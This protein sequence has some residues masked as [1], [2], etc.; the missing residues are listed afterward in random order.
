MGRSPGRETRVPVCFQRSLLPKA[1]HQRQHPPPRPVPLT[2]S[3]V[4][5]HLV[6]P[7]VP[8]GSGWA[9]PESHPG[10][11][12]TGLGLLSPTLVLITLEGWLAPVSPTECAGQSEQQGGRAPERPR[13]DFLGGVHL[14]SQKQHLPAP[15]ARQ[16]CASSSAQAPPLASPAY[17][18][19]TAS[20]TWS[21]LPRVTQGATGDLRPK[22]MPW[23]HMAP[24]TRELLEARWRPHL[25]VTATW[26]GRTGWGSTGLAMPPGSYLALTRPPAA[27]LGIRSPR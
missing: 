8:P 20:L 25:R 5:L 13:E 26:S 19:E 21:R 7:Q 17:V 3:Q 15:P 14:L 10:S 18:E 24:G 16:V 6:H 12:E 1:P 22:P 23:A 11:L 27:C 4:G 2:S 9:A